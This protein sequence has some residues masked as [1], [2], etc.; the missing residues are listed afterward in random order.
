M[1]ANY[2]LVQELGHGATSQVVTA[3]HRKTDRMVAIKVVHFERPE[4]QAT[5]EREVKLMQTMQHPRVVRLFDAFVEEGNGYIVMQYAKNGDLAEYIASQR[6]FTER[7]IKRMFR[8]IVDGVL[9]LHNHHIV[10]RDLKPENILLD[11]NFHCLVSDFG[12]AKFCSGYGRHT[13]CGTPAYAAPEVIKRE[14]YSTAADVWSLGVI[15]IQ[16]MTGKYPFAAPTLNEMYHRIVTADYEPMPTDWSQELVD[17]VKRLIVTDPLERLTIEQLATHPWFA[18][19]IEPMGRSPL[20]VQYVTMDVM[21][22][23]GYTMEEIES[24]KSGDGDHDLSVIFKILYA[25]EE[26]KRLMAIN[27]SS[28]ITQGRCSIASSESSPSQVRLRKPLAFMVQDADRRRS[29]PKARAVRVTT[30][31][32]VALRGTCQIVVPMKTRNHRTLIT[33]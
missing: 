28:H 26:T 24:A 14:E 31:A 30:P 8:Q 29:N 3:V 25:E 18:D 20:S 6:R 11:R 27:S 2:A 22:A 4:R 10:H 33:G 7:S 5:F 12:M 23:M 32:K 1:I 15:L 13:V 21:Q 19:D 17:L 9:Y 16:M